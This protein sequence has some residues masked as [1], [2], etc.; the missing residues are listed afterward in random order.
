M[1]PQWWGFIS[2]TYIIITILGAIFDSAFA[3]SLTPVDQLMQFKVFNMRE[4]KVLFADLVVPLPTL[5]LV[6]NVA[7][8]AT[9]DFAFFRQGDLLNIVRLIVLIPLGTVLSILFA[10]QI[11]PVLMQVIATARGL[12]GR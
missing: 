1:S 5:S 7:R 8:I 12:F 2:F 11:G 6:T 9:W 4:F 3:T 10:T